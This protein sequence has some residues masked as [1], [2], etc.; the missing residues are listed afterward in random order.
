M[1]MK[2]AK[3][4]LIFFIADMLGFTAEL[5]QAAVRELTPVF[6]GLFNEK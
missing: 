5:F 1:N 3:E 2:H 6:T 4:M